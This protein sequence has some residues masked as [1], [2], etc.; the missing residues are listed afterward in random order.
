MRPGIIGF[1]TGAA[2]TVL[3]VAIVQH[4]IIKSVADDLAYRFSSYVFSDSQFPWGDLEQGR[5][6]RRCFF[7]VSMTTTFYDAQYHEVTQADKPGRTSKQSRGS[8]SKRKPGW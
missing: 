4:L 7:P 1:I 2:L 3:A 8:A 5:V 6:V